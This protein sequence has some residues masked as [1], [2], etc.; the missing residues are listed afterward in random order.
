MILRLYIDLFSYSLSNTLV[1]EN[2]HG[3]L[4]LQT[5]SWQYKEGKLID[6]KFKEMKK[7]S[8]NK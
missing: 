4:L 1:F 5:P 8:Q 3:S 7:L 6:I 2:A